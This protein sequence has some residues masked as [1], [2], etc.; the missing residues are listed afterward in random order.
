MLVGYEDASERV[1][2]VNSTTISEEMINLSSF[3]Q[4]GYHMICDTHMIPLSLE[5][6]DSYPS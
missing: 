2:D 4:S 1:G 6:R 3:T 5:V